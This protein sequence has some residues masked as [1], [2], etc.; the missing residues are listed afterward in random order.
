MATNYEKLLGITE[1]EAKQ[2]EAAMSPSHSSV[3][4]A[5]P[6]VFAQLEQAVQQQLYDRQQV[7]D[8]ARVDLNFLAGLCMPDAMEYKFPPVLCLAFQ[9]V[10]EGTMS[11]KKFFR[12]ALGIPRGHAKTTLVKLLLVWMLCFSQ[13][14][15]LLVISSTEE[16]AI[17]I[18]R[19]VIMML[20]ESNMVAIFGSWTATVEVKQNAEKIFT[21]Q[22]RRVVLKAVGVGG[23]VRGS[24]Q[25]HE[26]PDFMVFED[27]QT[28]EAADSEVQSR[29]IENWL[30]G[31]A[32]KARSP[33]GCVFLFVANMY[34]TPYSILRK[35]KLNNMWV[36]FIC[37]AI[38]ADGTAL[39]PE[40]H[41][42]EMLLEELE[43][44][45]QAGH[46]EIFL[47]ELMNETDIALNS[48]YDI[49][50]FKVFEPNPLFDSPQARFVVIDPAKGGGSTGDAVGIGYV[51][52]YDGVPLLS[53]VVTERFTPLQAIHAALTF[54]F[55]TGCR[56]IGCESNAYQATFLFWF[57]FICKQ[58]SI[59]GIHFVE[60]YSLHKSK[61]ARV[62]DTIKA[63]EAGE[64]M[65]TAHTKPPVIKQ[66]VE[67]NPLK[68]KNVDEILDLLGFT[69]ALMQDSLALCEA[70]EVL[71]ATVNS[72]VR[73]KQL[74]ETCS[75]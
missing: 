26:R 10:T 18:L 33:K 3:E 2:V 40:V 16:H 38:L 34:P 15:F 37:G 14:R 70:Q 44:D 57:D 54:C 7:M 58:L 23:K 74:A 55:E 24:N 62:A 66:V 52:V 5:A 49:S 39:W 59:E 72:K 22:G 61:N 50:K 1:A 20:E 63:L 9:M 48:S 51:E 19:D 12:L 17:N 64:V 68:T 46:P 25:G 6:E 30:Y 65:L 43:H 47:S 67:Y 31:T 73:S 71:E 56:V 41:P 75:F 4:D 21:Y 13:K 27:V 32:M 36:K 69:R 35:L 60:I 28:R 29:A 53:A 42:V 45:T 11:P 8:I